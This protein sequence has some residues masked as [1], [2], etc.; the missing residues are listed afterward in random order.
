MQ[1]KEIETYE[2]EEK[3]LGDSMFDSEEEPQK[4]IKEEVKKPKVTTKTL[5]K[6]E[7]NEIIDTLA[8]IEKKAQ[9]CQKN[10]LKSDLKDICALSKEL[11]DKLRL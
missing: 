11:Q 3:E 7:I 9:N 5:S 8:V 1:E 10:A 2:E 6:K 4:V